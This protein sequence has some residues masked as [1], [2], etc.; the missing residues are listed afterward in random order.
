V[1]QLLFG[2]I[3][4][5]SYKIFPYNSQWLHSALN[6]SICIIYEL[7]IE[8]KKQIKKTSVSTSTWDSNILSTLWFQLG[9]LSFVPNS[10][11]NEIITFFNQI[12]SSVISCVCTASVY[13][14]A[15]I[16]AGV[17]MQT[18]LRFWKVPSFSKLQYIQNH[19]ICFVIAIRHGLIW[20]QCN[21]DILLD[22]VDDRKCGAH[23]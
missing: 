9:I 10:L 2:A 18:P 15:P 19:Y 11:I 17:D 7:F 21:Q 1:F 22:S 23:W 3:V 16:S 14:D 4:R 20:C 13:L 6:I 12:S 8:L 5:E